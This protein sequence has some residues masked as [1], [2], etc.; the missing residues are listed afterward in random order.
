MSTNRRWVRQVLFTPAEKPAGYR[1]KKMSCCVLCLNPCYYCVNDSIQLNSNVLTL[2]CGGRLGWCS[3]SHCSSLENRCAQSTTMLCSDKQC[4]RDCFL[5][6]CVTGQPLQSSSHCLLQAH[7]EASRSLAMDFMGAG[8]SQQWVILQSGT[9]LH[10][11]A[12]W[13]AWAASQGH[14]DWILWQVG[15]RLPLLTCLS[16]HRLCSEVLMVSCGHES[17]FFFFPCYSWCL[18]VTCSY[19]QLIKK[20]S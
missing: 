19:A 7:G 1:F 8:R 2:L 12:V 3:N 20:T 9:V 13:W 6:M 14:L 10:H 11:G 16:L 15:L 4:E 18:V 17:F 5:T